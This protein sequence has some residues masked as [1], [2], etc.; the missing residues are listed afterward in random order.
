MNKLFPPWLSFI[1][2]RCVRVAALCGCWAL[3][4]LA[5]FRVSAQTQNLIQNGDFASGAI[6]PWKV[7]SGKGAEKNT[8]SSVNDGVLSLKISGACEKPWDRQV[9]QEVALESG[10]TYK[11]SFDAKTASSGKKEV[12]VV[13]ARKAQ[14]E[15]Y[16]LRRPQALESDWKSYSFQFTTK[17]ISPEDP[18]T[19]RFHLGQL[20][21]DTFFRTIKL[22]KV[23]AAQ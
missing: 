12:I 9:S 22:E 19:L 2:P 6:R 1:N 10:K 20:D 5:P 14:G 15:N 7:F 4:M 11:L 21:G 8:T 18:P 3:L 13:L 17:E 16:G 23:D